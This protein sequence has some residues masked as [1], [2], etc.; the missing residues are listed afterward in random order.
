D[1]YS[2]LSL[3]QSLKTLAGMG[4]TIVCTIHQ[5]RPDIFDMFDNLLLMK[6]G[7]VGYFGSVQQ[8]PD[9]LSKMGVIIPKGVNSADFVVDL[10]YDKEAEEP[11]RVEEEPVGGALNRVRYFENILCPDRVFVFMFIMA[12][13]SSI[14]SSLALLLVCAIPEVEGAGAIHSTVAGMMGTFAGFF[15]PPNVIPS[16]LIWLYYLSFYKYSFEA[17]NENQYQSD[18]ATVDGATVTVIGDYIKVDET[19]NRFT[20]IV[21][22]CFYPLIFHAV[23]LFASWGFTHK[24]QFKALFSFGRKPSLEAPISDDEVKVP[25][26]LQVPAPIVENMDSYES[27]NRQGLGLAHQAEEIAG[28]QTALAPGL[29]AENQDFEMI[30]K[31]PEYEPKSSVDSGTSPT[32]GQNMG[33]NYNLGPD[34]T[35][36][37]ERSMSS[38]AQPLGSEEI[39]K[40]S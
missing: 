40:E 13:L 24:A 27:I 36:D 37:D 14:G 39:T 38:P 9:Y 11:K 16:F 21:V 23:A 12:V 25:Q 10:T 7:E 15:I 1:A 31:S 18:S 4:Q 33:P 19:L 6:S 26:N 32:V 22:L 30:T 35:L 29:S 8:M 34:M 20:N 5:P 28:R 3:V 17:L 2:S